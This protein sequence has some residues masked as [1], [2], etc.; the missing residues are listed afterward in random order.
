MILYADAD[1]TL[2]DLD[3]GA[4]RVQVQG[5]RV[6]AHRKQPVRPEAVQH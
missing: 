6:T 2:T 5:T 4:L 3:G 1:Q